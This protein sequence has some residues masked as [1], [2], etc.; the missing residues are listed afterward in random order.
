MLWEQWKQ[1]ST[2]F[3]T[4]RYILLTGKLC[5]YSRQSD[6]LDTRN[7]TSR[8]IQSSSRLQEAC[9]RGLVQ[10]PPLLWLQWPCLGWWSC[11]PSHSWTHRAKIQVPDKKLSLQDLAKPVVVFLRKQ[12]HKIKQVD[13]AQSTAV[14]PR[15]LGL[16][17]ENGWMWMCG[18][19]Q[20]CA[21]QAGGGLVASVKWNRTPGA[22]LT[23]ASVSLSMGGSEQMLGPLWS[24]ECMGLSL[25]RA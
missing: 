10:I 15:G 14:S 9:P 21:A 6:G 25:A 1:A 11:G 8:K 17:E 20:A 7:W 18:R 3:S 24:T 22:D 23:E 19:S 16:A 4:K 5:T 12:D 2:S 13:V